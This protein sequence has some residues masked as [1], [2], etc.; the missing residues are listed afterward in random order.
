VI[1]AGSC[2]GFARL[3]SRRRLSPHVFIDIRRFPHDPN[4]AVEKVVKRERWVDFAQVVENVER[5][6]F[7]TCHSWAMQY[8]IMVL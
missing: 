4:F 6:N 7:K 8:D 2:R 5:I 1:S 3:D